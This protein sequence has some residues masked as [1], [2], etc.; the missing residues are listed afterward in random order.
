MAQ[1]NWFEIPAT[2]FARAVTFYNTLLNVALDEGMFGDIPH[3]FFINA[4]GERIGAVIAPEDAAPS[5][6]GSV[7]YL[8]AT[9]QLEEALSRVDQAGGTVLL[10]YTSIGPQGWIALIRDSEG[11]RIGLHAYAA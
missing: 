8:D 11:N 2:D 7:L 1:I 10:P 9:G 3:G 4:N 5:V 6:D